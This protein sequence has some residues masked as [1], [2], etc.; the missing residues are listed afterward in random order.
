MILA[1]AKLNRVPQGQGMGWGAW[2][3]AVMCRLDWVLWAGEN[4]TCMSS[5]SVYLIYLSIYESIY[6]SVYRSIYLFI[7]LSIYLSIY[8]SVLS[9]RPMAVGLFEGSCVGPQGP[10]ICVGPRGPHILVYMKVSR[11]PYCVGPRGPHICIG[12]RGP[13]LPGRY[14]G[15]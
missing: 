15:R 1:E 9:W 6:L 12:P 4:V 11:A 8:L 3:G 13:T 10:H 5:L 2:A 7:L 14:V